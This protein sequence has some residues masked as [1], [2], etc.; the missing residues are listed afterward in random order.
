[1]SATETLQF[2]AEAKQ[3]LELMIHSVYSE[4]DV[5][6]RELISNASDALDKLRIQALLHTE[7]NI[8]TGDL[9]VR[10][11]ADPEQRTLSIE[12]NGIGMDR[13]DI[14]KLLGTIAHSGTK[15]FF[16]GL[17]EQA[18]AGNAQSMIGQFG[19]GFYSCF[20]VADRVVVESRKWNA[21]EG[22]DWSSSGDGTFTVGTGQRESRGTKITLHL[23][24]VDEE[25]GM[26]DYTSYWVVSDI[27]KRY[28]DFISYPIKMQRTQTKPAEKEGGPPVITVEDNT[29]NSMKALWTRAKDEITPEE[30]KQFY[31]HVS[32]DWNSPFETIQFKAE[33]T[34][35]YHALTFIPEKAPMDLYYAEGYK[36]G[37]QLYVRRVFI[38]D[39]CEELLPSYLRFLRGVVDAQDL[40]LN[41]SREILQKDRHIEQIRKRLTKKT[42]DVLKD[43]QEQDKERYLKFWVEFGRA[44]KEG[45]MNDPKNRDAILALG[46]FRSTRG[47]EFV[48]LADYFAKQ[49]EGQ[50][51]I[52]YLTGESLDKLSTSPH[53]EAFRKKEVEVLLLTDPVDDVWLTSVNE[54]QGKTF[55][56]AAQGDLEL[57]DEEEVKKEKEELDQQSKDQATFLSWLSSQIGEVKEVRLSRRLTESPV[58]LVG[59][60]NA[61]TANLEKLMKAMGQEVPKN[62]RILEVNPTHPLIAGLRRDYE[63][64]KDD[65][66]LAKTAKLLLGIAVLSE[67]GELDSPGEFSKMVVDAL[68]HSL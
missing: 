7:E 66:G 61:M 43:I 51:N 6:L 20:I 47:E 62:K 2:Q 64:K 5:F 28:S 25:N 52:Y 38:M 55:V 11:H 65:P 63:E 21:T 46:L 56:N 13:E 44:L 27:V 22:V 12:D 57:G 4:K 30:Y 23:K 18:T 1:M 59:D 31:Q 29:L 39:D 53:L 35:E 37:L 34:F 16:E 49:A 68:Q 14:V 10:L 26:H 67:G 41:I 36:K 3:L 50:K 58:C 60:E 32:K 15:E 45:L 54:Y 33:G 40:P 42:L 19:V 48:S 17:K 24:P 8:E 9:Q